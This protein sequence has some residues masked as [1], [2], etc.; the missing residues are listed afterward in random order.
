MAEQLAGEVE[1]LRNRV[2]SARAEVE[3][4]EVTL[5]DERARRAAAE[6]QASELFDRVQEQSTTQ[7]APRV[8]G[9]ST[10]VGMSPLA[11][12]GEQV[13]VLQDAFA[14]LRSSMRAASDE[15]AMMD[16]TDSVQIVS[17]ALSQAVEEI[18][19]ARDALRALA[20]LAQPQE[21]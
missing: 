18:E 7:T 3:A 19:R 10:T 21:R 9:D 5:A 20:D 16:Q 15:A 12:A 11:A 14:S 17:T 6:Q 13:S 4:A 1:R 2:E 8:D